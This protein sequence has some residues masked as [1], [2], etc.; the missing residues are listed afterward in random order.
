MDLKIEDLK[1]FVGIFQAGTFSRASETLGLTQSALSQKIKRLEDSLQSAIFIRHPRS[2]ELTS[3]GNKL[4]SYAKDI[5]QQQENFLDSFDNM[6]QGLSGVVRIATYS[7]ILRS[8]II[9]KIQ[10][11][12]A[13][14][15]SLSIEFSTHEMFELP[16]ILK[17]NKADII[18]MDEHPNI[19]G[20]NEIQIGSEEYVIIEPSNKKLK[21]QTP[22]K[23][24]DHTPA[25]NATES[26]FRHCGLDLDYQRGFMGD[27]YSIIDGV[28]LGFGKA[29]MSKHLIENDRRFDIIKTRKKYYRP[30][31][32]SHFKQ[33]YYSPLFKEV[34]KQLNS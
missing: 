29:V 8:L 18:I 30:I 4:L 5:I 7:S 6:K 31:V 33:N 20:T 10:K 34:L 15:P 16:E 24:L 21:A 11:L 19:V 3:T 2:L 17:T 13:N 23:F 28:A 1:A 25:D 32:L 26:Y 12:I 14:N 9:P 27:V 22:N